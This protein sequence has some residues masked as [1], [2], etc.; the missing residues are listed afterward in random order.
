MSITLAPEVEQQIIEKL[1]T[2]RYENA[3]ELVREALRVLD[4]RE[5]LHRLREL[6]AEGDEDFAAGD[7]ESWSPALMELI[8]REAEEE[9]QFASVAP[10]WTE[11]RA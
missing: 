4:E 1:E 8:R 6:I 7:Y 3:S 10:P 2:G 9:E 5:K 11:V